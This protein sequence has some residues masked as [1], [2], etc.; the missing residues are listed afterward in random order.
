MVQAISEEKFEEEVLKS[1]S[2]VLVDF[3]A[4]WCGPCQVMEPVIEKLSKEI[5]DAKIVRVDVDKN[6]DL[7]S[8]YQVMSIPT[9]AIFHKGEVVDSSIGVQEASELKEKLEK[10]SKG[11]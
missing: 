5:K 6:P 9:F 11:A 2:P 3:Y 10:Y 4:D 1:E 7:S 8:K